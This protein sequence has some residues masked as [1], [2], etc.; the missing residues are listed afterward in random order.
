MRC[1]LSGVWFHV[2]AIPMLWALS[3]AAETLEV[4]PGKRFALPS[5]AIKAAKDGDVIEIDTAGKYDRDVT[6]VRAN[7]LT[8]RGVGEGRALLDAAR[9]NRIA[10]GFWDED[11]QEFVQA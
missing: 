2:V 6:Y 5:A 4:G 1:H 7:N 10:Q 8:I 9:D 3:G 11:K